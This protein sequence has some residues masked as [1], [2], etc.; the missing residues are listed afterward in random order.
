MRAI[1]LAAGEGN[2]LR[3]HTVDRPK[4]MVK[5]L[6]YPLVM[7]QLETLRET[8][9][10]EITL[11]TGYRA[12]KL[13]ELG[14]ATR[15]NPEYA[16]TN[17]V[18]TLMCA[19]DLLDGGDDVLIAYSDIVY[20]RRV[21]D[22]ILSARSP[23]S[24]TVDSNWQKLWRS[25]NED[26][27]I[28]AETLLVDDDGNIIELGKKPASLQQI[29]G[30]YMGLIKVRADHVNAFVEHYDS[31]DR[32]AVYDGKDFRNLY[33]TSFLQSLIDS[34]HPIQ[35]VRVAGGWLEV[36]TTGD[37]ALYERLNAEGQLD[38]LVNLDAKA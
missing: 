31:L 9:V 21:L 12:E 18:Y 11:V 25:R 28:D 29:E 36:D 33:M 37:L 30:Q 15:H 16:S 17:M 1:I 8:G 14:V 23:I 26:P 2:R 27:L 20:E 10:E 35:A 34:G 7:R 38:A 5:L 32:D 6:G 22:A 19:R 4:C 24:T 3:P 13:N